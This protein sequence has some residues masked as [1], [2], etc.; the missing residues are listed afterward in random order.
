MI[1]PVNILKTL[2]SGRNYAE[3]T[4]KLME[5]PLSDSKEKAASVPVFLAT[6]L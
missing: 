4:D 3:A 2:F 1:F 5:K 6:K